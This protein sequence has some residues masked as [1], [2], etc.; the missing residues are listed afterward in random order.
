MN[1]LPPNENSK[2]TEEKQTNYPQNN[3]WYFSIFRIISEINTVEQFRFRFWITGQIGQ[4]F[5]VRKNL[6]TLILREL[7]YQHP[8]YFPNKKEI[9]ENAFETRKFGGNAWIVKRKKC[10]EYRYE[11]P[12]F[13]FPVDSIYVTVSQKRIQF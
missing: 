3:N 2:E 9:V 4:L 1:F 10:R 8:V 13:V 6:L 7:S 12:S 11:M 5:C